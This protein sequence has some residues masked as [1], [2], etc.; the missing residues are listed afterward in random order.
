[1]HLICFGCNKYD[2]RVENCATRGDHNP[3]EQS[4][5]TH[6]LAKP[7]LGPEDSTYGPWMLPKYS[8]RKSAKNARSRRP[9][10]RVDGEGDKE[11]TLDKKESGPLR[12]GAGMDNLGEGG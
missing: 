1:M 9:Y 2:H 4:S 10:N 8:R 11:S 5:G 3:G 6:N 7:V 12:S